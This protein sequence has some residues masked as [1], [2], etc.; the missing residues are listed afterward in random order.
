MKPTPATVAA[1]FLDGRSIAGLAFDHLVTVEVIERLL[2][3][4]LETLLTR[5]IRR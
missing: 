1:T 2:R 4:R 5:K 3:R